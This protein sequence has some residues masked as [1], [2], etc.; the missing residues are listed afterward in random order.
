M[1]SYLGNTEQLGGMAKAPVAKLVAQDSNNLLGLGLFDQGIVNN[2]VLLPWQTV[3]V[4]IA[5]S[6]AL[7]AVDDVQ[8]RERELELLSQ[9]L[10]TSLEFTGLQR[11][12]LVEQR[13]NRNRID[14][15]GEDLEEDTEQPEVVVERSVKLLN[16]LEN[17]SDDGCSQNNSKHLTLEHIRKPKLEC[18]L[19]ET[20]L[21][22]EHKRV[23]VGDGQR[24]NRA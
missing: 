6:A 23:V 5:V 20:E 7:A 9:V 22:L 10:N 16:D 24:E 17:S 12:Q 19:V 21:L 13:Q 15:N 2:N 18:L 3:E 11:R 1:P 14:G 8:L 4:S